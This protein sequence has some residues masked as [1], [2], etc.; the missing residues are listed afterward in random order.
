MGKHA[1]WERTGGAAATILE[2]VAQVGGWQ[3][4]APGRKASAELQASYLETMDRGLPLC[5]GPNA[6]DLI[7]EVD[8]EAGET[9]R[10]AWYQ[11][12]FSMEPGEQIALPE[13]PDLWEI[14][15]RVKGIDLPEEY[16][17]HGGSQPTVR[18]RPPRTGS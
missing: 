5:F 18:G 16:A 8:A 1:I 13:T 6:R 9:D 14:F 12:R 17:R 3:G 4:A 2:R 15:G 10:K 11:Y 7:I